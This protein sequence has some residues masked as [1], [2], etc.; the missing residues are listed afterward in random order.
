MAEGQY[1]LI[2]KDNGSG[3]PDHIDFETNKTLGL[4]LI[5]GLAKQL[6]GKSTYS[7]NQ[8]SVFTVFFQDAA[9][10]YNS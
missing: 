3:L 8:G 2:Y 1:E 9:I 4:K 7:Y 5:K 6:L 10:R